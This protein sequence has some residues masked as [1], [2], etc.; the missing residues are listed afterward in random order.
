MR[1]SPDLGPDAIPDQ[2]E[3]DEARAENLARGLI[4][5]DDGMWAEPEDPSLV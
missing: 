4:E 5:V 3:E 2:F 1:I